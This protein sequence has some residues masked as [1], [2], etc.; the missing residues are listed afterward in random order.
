[1]SVGVLYTLHAV[2]SPHAALQ[3]AESHHGV[4]IVRHALAAAPLRRNEYA[5]ENGSDNSNSNGLAAEQ[6]EA[7]RALHARL[8][9]LHAALGAHGKAL[10][11]LRES[12]AERDRHSDQQLKKALAELHNTM[13]DLPNVISDAAAEKTAHVVKA[14]VADAMLLLAQEQQQKH[15][16]GGL[17]TNKKQ[18]GGKQAEGAK[19]GVPNIPAAE[20]NADVDEYGDPKPRTPF[21]EFLAVVQAHLNGEIS[22]NVMLEYLGV[23]VA[24]LAAVRPWTRH[25][26]DA[27]TLG[28]PHDSVEDEDGVAQAAKVR[29]M[30]VKKGFLAAK[31]VE[32]VDVGQLSLAVWAPKRCMEQ[33]ETQNGKVLVLRPCS[34][35][36]PFQQWK[37][38]ADGRISGGVNQM[39]DDCLAMPRLEV[40]ENVETTDCHRDDRTQVFAWRVH[41][42]H[43]QVGELVHKDSGRCVGV[44][45]ARPESELPIL[46]VQRC[47]RR[48]NQ[49]WTI[50][51]EFV[52][53]G[54][55]TGNDCMTFKGEESRRLLSAP[56]LH[57]VKDRVEPLTALVNKRDNLPTFQPSPRAR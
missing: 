7:K 21:P 45:D 50:D 51:S 20:N 31:E 26:V 44:S 47:Q 18:A 3:G 43:R 33:N 15:Q 57:A 46:Q 54:S 52:A 16:A 49:L 38:Q 23:K 37:L 48:C 10:T 8:E 55:R 12:M 39:G 27:E 41:G 17:P 4:P 36:G 19:A 29:A 14:A 1:M 25:P 35:G 32:G 28:T 34:L 53:R 24:A 30:L 6:E 40:G 11:K 5:L 56:A 2:H 9:G 22:H 13:R 42:S